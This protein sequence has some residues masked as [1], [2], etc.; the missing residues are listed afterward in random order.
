[1]TRPW[2]KR[3]HICEMPT[4]AFKSFDGSGNWQGEREIPVK[5][6]V[7]QDASASEISRRKDLRWRRVNK[8]N[9]LVKDSALPNAIN[10]P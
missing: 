6:A 9:K 8:P 3:L 2:A 5:T 7:A 1:M 4:L 10:F